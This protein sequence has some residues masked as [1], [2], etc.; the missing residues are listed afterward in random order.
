LDELN[1]IYKEMKDIMEKYL[2]NIH[3]GYV[4]SIKMQQIFL[5]LKIICE[6][7]NIIKLT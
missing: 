6:L 5:N 2:K 1:N 7:I 4:S 3:L